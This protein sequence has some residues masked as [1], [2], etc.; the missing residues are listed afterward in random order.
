MNSPSTLIQVA[1]LTSTQKSWSYLPPLDTTIACCIKVGMRVRVPF[2]A[3]EKIGIVVDIQQVSTLPPY[4]LKTILDVIDKKPLFSPHL[5][6]LCTWTSQYYHYPLGNVLFSAIPKML[7]DG[8]PGEFESVRHWQKSQTCS[9]EQSLARSPK[10]F[11]LLSH[12]DKTLSLSDDNI[13]AL[14]YSL[15]LAKNLAK[16]GFL[17]I[18]YQ[19]Q[20]PGLL[21]TKKKPIDIVPNQEQ[22]T[23]IE[24][25]G[26]NL[27]RFQPFLL[28]GVTGS[29]KTQV[30]IKVIEKI[31]KKGLQ[32][33]ILVPEIGLTQQTVDRF[34]AVFDVP[35]AILHSGLS[36]RER[37]NAWLMAHFG[38]AKIIFGTRSAIFSSLPKLGLIIIDEEHDSSYKQQEKC[39]YC[40]RDLAIVRAKKA[41][42]PII[43]GSATPSLESFIHAKS[44]YFEHLILSSRPKASSS[45]HYQL[46]DM[47][48][49]PSDK[50]ISPTLKKAI[51][52]HLSNHNQVLLFLNRRGFAPVLM[53]Y[54][55]GWSAKC[56]RCDSHLTLHKK[57]QQLNCHHCQ[58]G[59]CAPTICP[60][61]QH[62]TLHPLGAGTQRIEEEVNF[63]FPDVTKMRIDKD[64]SSAKGTLNENLSTIHALDAKLLIG[65]QM[66]SKG[67]HF[68]HVTLVGILN[69]D[70][71]LYSVDF[72][73]IER[74]GQLIIQVSGRAGR[75]EKPGEVLIQTHY[76]ENP[77]LQMLTKKSYAHFAN[78]LLKE[79]NQSQLPPYTYHAIIRAQAYDKSKVNTFL[80]QLKSS[81]LHH[82]QTLLGPIPAP[83]EKRLGRFRAQLL[84]Q[85][86]NRR[87][88][89]T[90]LKEAR[91]NILSLPS[92]NTVKYSLDVDP[93][94][95]Y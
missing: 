51:H 66:L 36:E 79:R 19:Q 90:L 86:D 11:S 17:D 37:L 54:Q 76:P 56:T 28:D 48:H 25:I 27:N 89:Q 85:S 95:L 55:C 69:A 7:R 63:L 20:K 38:E 2:R 93:I 94:D 41:N 12:F 21:H 10:Q 43:L 29:G 40:A 50:I 78:H 82:K 59:Q 35:I 81:L 6:S 47:R 67:H 5:L 44:H 88:L 24:T 73:A 57:N 87:Q 68:P 53:C 77:L 9:N 46:V 84:I 16:N 70:N 4:V 15:Q 58:S 92:K 91:Q 45:T 75:A 61:C 32:A 33:L 22:T 39:R 49:L 74:L 62:Q 60:D 65:T 71:G 1:L 18:Y 80:S 64:T 8:K 42:I 30:Y 14:G 72:R 26:K 83:M 31:M 52:K 23:A 13:K 3:G 34:N